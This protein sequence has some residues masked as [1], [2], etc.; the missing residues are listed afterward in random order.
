[1]SFICKASAILKIFLLIAFFTVNFS[2]ITFA[3]EVEI[4]NSSDG[5]KRLDRSKF[6]SDFYQL[7]NFYQAQINPLYCS[8]AS[9]VM[10]LNAFNKNGIE[11]QKALEI[12]KP[13]IDGGGI[14]EFKSYSQLTF[15]ND[16]TDKIKDRKII[17]YQAQNKKGKFDPGLN[18]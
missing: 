11:S 17:N 13:E 16:K 4:W 2:K 6:K 18:L 3:A 7:V 8:A 5:L 15:F 14:S 9:S 12:N 10:V 1:M